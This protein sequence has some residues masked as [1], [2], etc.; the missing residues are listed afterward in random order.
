MQEI[1]RKF[2]VLNEDYKKQAFAKKK[3]CQGYLS[4]DLER[5]VRI[6]VE[7]GNGFLTIKG[8]SSDDGL[9]R[10][11]FEKEITL[12]EALALLKI[13][14]AGTIIKT[15]HFVKASALT[16]EVD[17]FSGENDGLVV[18]EIELESADQFFEKPQWLGSEVTGDLRYYNAELSKNP[19]KKWS[20]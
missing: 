17:E 7:D 3:L 10:F 4:K 19:F 14:L 12:E 8:A 11:E 13:C 1:E 6:R 9:E 18:A 15:R 16:F 2:L 5:T 20:K